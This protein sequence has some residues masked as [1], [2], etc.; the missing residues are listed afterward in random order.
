MTI[1]ENKGIYC[2]MNG[3]K[4]RGYIDCREAKIVKSDKNP[5]STEKIP[6]LKNDIEYEG[7]E[8][9]ILFI[10][11]LRFVLPE[12]KYVDILF[13]LSDIEKISKMG[14]SFSDMFRYP[15]SIYR[16]RSIVKKNFIDL[17]T[18]LY[19]NDIYVDRYI[20]GNTKG[21]CPY[22][23]IKGSL[24]LGIDFTFR[25]D[26]L[27]PYVFSILEKIDSGMINYLGLSFLVKLISDVETVCKDE[28]IDLPKPSHFYSEA[29]KIIDYQQRLKRD[30]L[31]KAEEEKVF[32]ENW[33]YGDYR[34]YVLKTQKDFSVEGR[35][36]KNCMS[37]YYAN[38]SIDT[39]YCSIR[40]KDSMNRP[41][42]SAEISNTNTTHPRINQFLG[43][44]NQAPE[45]FISDVG[46]MK[47]SLLDFIIEHNKQ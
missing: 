9:C 35:L 29:L 34:C 12:C 2:I 44:C 42:I 8:N 33:S 3:N 28:N 46:E 16:L 10:N 36:N 39:I 43:T 24:K 13:M 31:N 6:F 18:Y 47:Q 11:N 30:E 25:S 45:L 5:Y 4:I 1:T 20:Y 38:R 40:L 17:I 22:E 27:T 23:V 32:L 21:D 19:K 15:G 26:K 41:I 7:C 14:I 37:T